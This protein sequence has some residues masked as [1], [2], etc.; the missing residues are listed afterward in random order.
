[1]DEDEMLMAE[2]GQMLPITFKLHSS[3]TGWRE[4]AGLHWHCYQFA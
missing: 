4:A 1:M 2:H 3:L